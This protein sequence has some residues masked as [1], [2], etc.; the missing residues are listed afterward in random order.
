[1]IQRWNNF[2]KL[3]EALSF[4]VAHVIKNMSRRKPFKFKWPEVLFIYK[5]NMFGPSAIW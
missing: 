2:F 1:M 4:Q 3:V 5:I